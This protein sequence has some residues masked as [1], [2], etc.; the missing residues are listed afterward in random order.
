M[1][2]EWRSANG[3]TEFEQ[4]LQEAFDF[5]EVEDDTGASS[6]NGAFISYSV[7]NQSDDE[8][9]EGDRQHGY[10]YDAMEM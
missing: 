7:L 3:Q 10:E 8:A 9:D 2:W 1:R 4:V 5:D 6:A